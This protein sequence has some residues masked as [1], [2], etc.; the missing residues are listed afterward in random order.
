M[1]HLYDWLFSPSRSVLIR[2]M[3]DLEARL[4]AEQ[5]DHAETKAELTQLR[6]NIRA[7]L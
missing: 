4:G 7:L 5:R 1:K 6:A 3:R 2:R